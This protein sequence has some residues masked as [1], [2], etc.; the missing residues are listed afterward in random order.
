MTALGA[1]DAASLGFSA[2]KAP[3]A[4]ESLIERLLAAS[5]RPRLPSPFGV[6][7]NAREV[8]I[9]LEK[10][11]L[12]LNDILNSSQCPDGSR[13]VLTGAGREVMA[14]VVIRDKSLRIEF[15]SADDVFVVEPVAR[16]GDEHPEALIRVE[17]GHLD[18]VG[19]PLRIPSS[20][21][22]NYPLRVVQFVDA[23]FSIR[24]CSLQGAF[25]EGAQDYPVVEWTSTTPDSSE[26]AFGLI[27]NSFVGGRFQGVGG[28]LSEK[29]LEIR[30]CV[31]FT[32]GTGLRCTATHGDGYLYV[33]DSTLSVANALFRLN[34]AASGRVHVFTE[35]CVFGPAVDADP[36]GP[37]V[38][39]FGASA[40]LSRNL[41]WWDE[42][43][44]YERQFIRYRVAENDS[45]A[46]RQDFDT[47]WVRAW[48]PDH[49]VDPLSGSTAV[50]LADQ[51]PTSDKTS[52]ADF[53]LKAGSG[54]AGWAPDG[55]A[56]GAE[57]A[58]VGPGAADAGQPAASGSQ[59]PNTNRPR[60]QP[61]F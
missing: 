38:L 25:R 2:A 35:R 51:L 45:A 8:R 11:G 32:L 39:V 30:N 13:V 34:P 14:P 50:I 1:A 36:A 54:A 26:V 60:T 48:G 47:D 61:D 43:S 49:I 21:T 57:T 5:E 42:R 33:A 29:L 19:A 52:A 6:A 9:D 16:T 22:R 24:N 41:T 27:E 46:A 20:A 55:S 53:A 18:L 12:K 23:T 58:A 10:D 37:A 59:S 28:D 3:E 44:A 7:A 4:P 17:R 40:E 56:V 15:E 31:V